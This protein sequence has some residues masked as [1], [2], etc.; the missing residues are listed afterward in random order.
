MFI[1]G[2]LISAFSVQLSL[3]ELKEQKSL[4]ESEL[5]IAKYNSEKLQNEYDKAMDDEH[6]IEVAK[7][8]LKYREPGE[9]IYYNDLY[10]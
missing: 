6:I 8:R 9:V 7:E 3:N 1:I 2:L 4:L 5:K 10:D